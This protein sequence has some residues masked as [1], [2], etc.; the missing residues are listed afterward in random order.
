M[1]VYKIFPT[2]DASIYSAYP[3]MNTGVDSIL[4][5]SNTAPDITPSPRVARALVQFSQTEIDDIIENKISG[6]TWR[7]NLRLFIA[8]A[9][10][11]TTNT[12]IEARPVS[13]S[14]E[15]GSGQYLDSPITD[16]G[17]SW[18]WKNYSGSSAW[19][20]E[21]GDW[22]NFPLATQSF[23]IRSNKDLNINVTTAVN[24]IYNNFASMNNNGFI[25]KLASSSEFVPSQSLQPTFKYYSVDTNTIY[26]PCLEF[27]WDDFE[28][29]SSLLQIDTPDMYLA[30]DNNQ[31][32]FNTQSV[33]RFRI[34]VRPEF[35][36]RTFQTSSYY[37][38]NYALPPSSSYAIK[39]LDTN[40]FVVDFDDNFTRISCDTTS[41]YFDVYMNGFEPE[42]YYKVLIKTTIGSNVIIKDDNYYFKVVN[43]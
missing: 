31:G 4:E 33:N 20:S 26:P 10:G 25:V 14:W 2:R 24:M 18:V 6:S 22:W 42:R 27:K 36:V 30:L 21:G 19:S 15:N 40:E 13:G 8:E 7:S 16:N 34:N 29:S 12:I 17:V 39:D 43:G 5:V 11:I 38:R 32:E 23:D 37:T 41:S 1:A 35:P 28:Y 9:E 3:S